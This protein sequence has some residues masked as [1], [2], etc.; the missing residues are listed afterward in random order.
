MKN[1]LTMMLLLLLLTACNKQEQPKY[2]IGIS[3]CSADI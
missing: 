2:T 1:L 3:Q